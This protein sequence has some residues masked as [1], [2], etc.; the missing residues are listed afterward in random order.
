M[1]PLTSHEYIDEIGFRSRDPDP[2]TPLSKCLPGFA[3]WIT[4][5]HYPSEDAEPNQFMAEFGQPHDL[6]IVHTA[7]EK[8][9]DVQRFDQEGRD[10]FTTEIRS[11][12]D[13]SPTQKQVVLIQG[14]IS[15]AWV[16]AIGSKYDIDPEF[17]KQ[18]LDFLSEED[19]TSCKSGLTLS[20]LT[21]PKRDRF[22]LC[23][24]SIFEHR[25]LKPGDSGALK[26]QQQKQK[27]E[28][29]A[30][31]ERL[32][33]TD[34][35]C[36][37]SIAREY[38]IVCPRFSV[39]EQWIS[40]C[41]KVS[42]NGWTAIV[43]ADQGRSLTESPPGP[44]T[45]H[46]PKDAAIPLPSL[47]PNDYLDP[48]LAC[49]PLFDYAS[50]SEVKLHDLLAVG[51]ECVRSEIT[52]GA[53]FMPI[54]EEHST[55][56][57]TSSPPT[58]S[59]SKRSRTHLTIIRDPCP[60]DLWHKMPPSTSQTSTAASEA[61]ATK[62]PGTAS[63]ACN[64]PPRCGS[65]RCNVRLTN[66]SRRRR[67]VVQ[68]LFYICCWILRSDLYAISWG[69]IF[70]LSLRG[71]LVGMGGLFSFGVLLGLSWF[72]CRVYWGFKGWVEDRI[73]MYED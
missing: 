53:N 16:A 1:P 15:P 30:Y 42:Y 3:K 63:R 58:E 65:M 26:A 44:W 31:K 17:F 45:M 48:L 67:S 28:I 52:Q 55:A 69:L 37:D 59:S 9:W 12:V 40:I 14:F 13:A 57:T 22:R 62:W 38:S 60:G 46:T 20:S 50:S 54:G 56:P 27:D 2:N 72:I 19:S 8:G 24:R 66:G 70:G 51:I 68:E 33:T 10:A 21:T 35:R 32:G 36:G 43:W 6:V 39:M 49:T 7:G 61:A 64:P 73:V 11:S 18:H 71:F 25:D 47:S 5:E 29:R 34:V 23:V 41:I 4:Q